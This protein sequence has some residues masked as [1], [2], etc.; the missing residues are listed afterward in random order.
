MADDPL[1]ESLAALS[2]FFVGDLTVIETLN[3]VSELTVQAVP[4]ADLVGLTILVEGRQ[5]T[6]VFTDELAPEVDQTQYDTGEGPCLAAFEEQRIFPI[7]STRED[8]RWPAFRKAAADHGIGSTLSVP[9]VVDG[10]ATGA[11]NLYSFAERAFG[12]NEAR[13]ATLFSTQAATVLANSQAYWDARD[14]N[15]RLGEAMEFRAAIEQAKGMLMITQGCDPAEA[16]S[17]LVRASQR[18]NIP[19]RDIAVRMVEDAT[20]RAA[21]KREQ[22]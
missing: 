11:M 13:T 8:G 16:F 21:Q 22:R 18:E 4:A 17:L 15:T 2:R 14:L 12:E 5:R 1:A 9:M 7:E 10:K 3:R 6:A 20:H 19:L